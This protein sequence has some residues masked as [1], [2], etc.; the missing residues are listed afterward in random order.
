MAMYAIAITP[1][2]HLLEDH[3]IKQAWYADNAGGSLKALREWWDDILLNWVQLLVIISQCLEDLVNCIIWMK[4]KTSLKIQDISTIEGKRHLDAAMN[5]V[6]LATAR[7]FHASKSDS[8]LS[9]DMNF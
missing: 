6:L 5:T 8:D 4:L 9:G 3:G 2:I 7:G 1:L